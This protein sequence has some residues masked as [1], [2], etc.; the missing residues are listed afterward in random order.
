MIHLV[1]ILLYLFT[2]IGIFLHRNNYVHS[3][4]KL[5]VNDQNYRVGV[6]KNFVTSPFVKIEKLYLDIDFQNYQQLNKNREIGISKNILFI[7][8][9]SKNFTA[10]SQYLIILSLSVSNSFLLPK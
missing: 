2:L 3:F 8:T 6:L 4:K 10:N 1:V 7:Q 5:L 9:F